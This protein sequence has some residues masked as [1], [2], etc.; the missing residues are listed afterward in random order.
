MLSWNPAPD[1]SLRSRMNCAMALLLWP[2]SAIEKLREA[3]GDASE[4]ERP[5]GRRPR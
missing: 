1:F 5:T 3:A 2:S 4:L